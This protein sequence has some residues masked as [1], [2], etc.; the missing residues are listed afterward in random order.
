MPMWH[1]YLKV[2]IHQISNLF[3]DIKSHQQTQL[4]SLEALNATRIQISK[5]WIFFYFKQFSNDL[6]WDDGND[7][8]KEETDDVLTNADQG[9][10]EDAIEEDQNNS[11]NVSD[12]RKNSD[13]SDEVGSWR[14]RRQ[15]K[16]IMS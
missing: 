1:S 10:S 13:T 15:V 14:D 3:V 16:I 11:Q 8:D 12:Q 4:I 2:H 6:F 7:A 9:G 5:S